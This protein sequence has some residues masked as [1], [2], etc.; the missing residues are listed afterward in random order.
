MVGSCPNAPFWI[1]EDG[2]RA[3]TQP[4]PRPGR[5]RDATLQSPEA[6]ANRLAAL[7]VASA[8]DWCG[9]RQKF[10]PVPD[11]GERVRMVPVIGTA[12]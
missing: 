1:N 9:H 11:E 5:G 12:K 8:V 4:C 6:P 3:Q 2:E 7:S 10:I